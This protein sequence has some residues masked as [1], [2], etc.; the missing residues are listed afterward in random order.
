MNHLHQRPSYFDYGSQQQRP[1]DSNKSTGVGK[2]PNYS[3]SVNSNS[4][5]QTS[6]NKPIDQQNLNSIFKRSKKPQ[7]YKI[8]PDLI[9]RPKHIDEVYGSY[10][11][12]SLYQTSI[13]SI[14]PY[15][16]SFYTVKEIDNSSPRLIR[17]SILKLPSNPELLNSSQLIFGVYCQP[18]AEFSQGD[19]EI[20]QIPVNEDI[21]RCVRC[22]CYVNNKFVFQNNKQGKRI[23]ICNCCSYELELNLTNPAI[24]NEYFSADLSH[25]VE[26]N[27]P[28]VDFIAPK[29][30]MSKLAFSPVYVI[31][32]DISQLSIDLGFAGYVPF[33]NPSC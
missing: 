13:D 10:T 9:P 26:L 8:N 1:S 29:K 3:N 21:L 5:K 15:T 32:I 33:F 30:F 12:A 7:D 27:S 20:P 11:D 23:A 16:N 17:S 18:F 25:T 24:K 6:L 4:G 2:T 19:S 31:M 14:P 22:G 28:T